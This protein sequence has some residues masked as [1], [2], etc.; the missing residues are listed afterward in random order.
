MKK[1]YIIPSME[2]LNLRT[3]D[4]VMYI[5]GP[6][7]AAPDPHASGAPKRHDSVF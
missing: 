2:T 6:A 7:S 3:M 5:T 1:Q 4:A